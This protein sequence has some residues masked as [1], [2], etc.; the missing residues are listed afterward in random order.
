VE[1]SNPSCL[2]DY[3][4]KAFKELVMASGGRQSFSRVGTPGD[5][6]W[7]E[8]FF[9]NMKK[10]KFHWMHYET[11]KEIRA[12]VFHYIEVLYNRKRAQKR[13]GYVSPKTYFERFRIQQLSLV[14]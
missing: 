10:E 3:T 12:V 1:G 9:A 13:L 11:R 5:N 2:V 6:A 4:S 14:A 8:S 7:S